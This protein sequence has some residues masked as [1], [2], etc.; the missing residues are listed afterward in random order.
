MQNGSNREVALESIAFVLKR[1][2]NVG[3][4]DVRIMMKLVSK[5][6]NGFPANY[7]RLNDLFLPQLE[8][9]LKMW[10]LSDNMDD[11]SSFLQ[12]L[13]ADPSLVK[14]GKALNH[15]MIKVKTHIYY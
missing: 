8:G 4:G 14:M 9:I 5:I 10:I 3:F 1:N 7:E 13:I 15:E 6:A 11:V 12:D 2:P